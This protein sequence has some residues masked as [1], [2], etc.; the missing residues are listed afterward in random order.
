[1]GKEIRHVLKVTENIHTR[2]VGIESI[3]IKPQNPTF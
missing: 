3:T 2:Q 1:M